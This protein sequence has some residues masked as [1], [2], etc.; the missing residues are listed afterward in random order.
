MRNNRCFKLTAL[1]LILALAFSLG[2]SGVLAEDNNPDATGTYDGGYDFQEEVVLEGTLIQSAV[3]RDAKGQEVK[4]FAS[5]DPNGSYTLN[6]RIVEKEG[7][8]L[9]ESNLTAMVYPLQNMTA[10]NGSNEMVEWEFDAE[11]GKLSFYWLGSSD[12]SFTA[13]VSIAPA[14]PATND[15]SDS[16]VLG[17]KSNVILGTPSFEEGGRNRLAA[18]VFTEKNGTIRPVT[19]EDPVWIL[20]HVTGDYYTIQSQNTG[21]YLRISAAASGSYKAKS[22]YLVEA[23]EATAQKI[24]VKDRGNGYYSFH[25]DGAAISNAG[26]NPV[27]GFASFVDAKAGTGNNE[28]FKLYQASQLVH[29]ATVD[30]SG[31]WV[32]RN[33]AKSNTLSAEKSSDVLLKANAGYT[34]GNY[35]LTNENTT[36]FTFEH[37][38]RDWYIV[39]TN[40]GYLNIANGK[41][42]IS[43]NPQNLL[44]RTNNNYASIILATGEYDCDR[45]FVLSYNGKGYTGAKNGGFSD[46]TRLTLWAESATLDEEAGTYILFNINGGNGATAPAAIVGEAGEKVTLP[47]L[48]ATKNGD[49][50]IGWCEVNSVYL[51]KEGTNHTYHDVYKPGTAYTLKSG[52]NT[53]YAIYNYKGTKKVRFGIRKDGI[54]Q[55]EPNGYD[56][57]GYIG[58]F[59]QDLDILKETHW[60]IDIDSTKPV[61]GYYVVN[62]ITANLNWMPSAEEIAKALREEG[63]VEFD[64]ETQYIHYYVMKCVADTTW[65]I[66]GVIRNKEKVGISYNTNS[67]GTDKTQIDNMPGGAQVLPGTQILIGAD[68]GT[69]NVKTPVRPGYTFVGWNTEEDGSGITY[70]DGR[71]LRLTENLNLY[72]QWEEVAEE[73]MEIRI[74]AANWT[75]GKPAEAGTEII[76]VAELTGLEGKTYTLQWQYTTD[77]ETWYDVEGAHELTLTYEITPTTAQ[78]HWR[79]VAQNIR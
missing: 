67:P 29:D 37:V 71:Y 62:D 31:T 4:D 48:N 23:T 1:L 42:N 12:E 65:K 16:Y 47:A 11:S 64:P 75:P 52:A 59:E 32:I 68:K 3:I 56:V 20:K 77:M 35:L 58:H 55:D 72:A 38:N 45:T 10:Q 63:G 57:S 36:Y 22:L 24:L 76:L 21:K 15:L 18:S 54:I 40:G 70:E 5:A 73:K 78:Y 30:Y 66:D 51:K 33:N 50:F 69:G 19:D 60:V 14:Y 46:N 39:W 6:L 26:N 25:C 41:A 49:V 53:L 27:N 17:T 61:N 9:A 28:Q 7:L 79:C 8:P 43:A 13:T 44:V 2:L 74:S 34:L